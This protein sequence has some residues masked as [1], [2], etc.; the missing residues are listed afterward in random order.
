MTLYKF[1]LALLSGGFFAAGIRNLKSYYEFT[2][3]KASITITSTDPS[4]T[5]DAIIQDYRMGA[6]SCLLLG[7]SFAF[8]SYPDKK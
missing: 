5:L 4:V 2:S 6:I 8:F 7:L 3:R 1:F